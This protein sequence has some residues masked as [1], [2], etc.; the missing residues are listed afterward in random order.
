[1]GSEEREAAS[2]RSFLRQSTETALTSGTRLVI[3]RRIFSLSWASPEEDF[4]TGTARTDRHTVRSLRPP[5]NETNCG[6]MSDRPA[7]E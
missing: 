7:V 5:M 1:M 4:G 6:R 3:M 2:E